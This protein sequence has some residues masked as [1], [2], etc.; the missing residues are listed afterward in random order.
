MTSV[1]CLQ[2]LGAL[3]GAKT[4]NAFDMPATNLGN[5]YMLYG[6]L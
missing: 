1:K 5:S 4:R 3:L 2:A 6:L